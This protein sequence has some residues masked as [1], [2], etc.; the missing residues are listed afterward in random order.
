MAVLSDAPA[1]LGWGD[2]AVAQA[3]VVARQARHVWGLAVDS[4]AT[5][6]GQAD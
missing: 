4:P 5:P 1:I 3:A 2:R 6:T